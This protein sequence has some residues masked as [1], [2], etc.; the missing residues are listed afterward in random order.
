MM[1][2]PDLPNAV[3]T[4]WIAYIQL[5]TFEIQHKLG[6]AHCVLDGLS[7]RCQAEDDS[8]Y[9]DDEV[10]IEEGIKLVKALPMNFKSVL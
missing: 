6:I 8:E 9:S 2:M 7:C 1:T 10:D 5:F 3:M 4:C